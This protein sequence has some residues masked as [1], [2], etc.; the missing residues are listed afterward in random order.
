LRLTGTILPS[1]QRFAT[2]QCF[3]K[4]AS[5]GASRVAA[6]ATPALVLEDAFDKVI[7]WAGAAWVE[8]SSGVD[9]ARKPKSAAA[10]GGSA[11][12]GKRM[13]R[14][15]E[16]LGVVVDSDDDDGGGAE[17]GDGG[18]DGGDG[19]DEEGPVPRRT[20]AKRARPSA[21]ATVHDSD[22]E[23]AVASGG[24][25]VGDDSAPPARARR[26]AAAGSGTVAPGAQPGSSGSKAASPSRLQSMLAARPGGLLGALT[27]SAGVTGLRHW[28]SNPMAVLASFR[29]SVWTS[30]ARER[31]VHELDGGGGGGGATVNASVEVSQSDGED[32]I[33]LATAASPARPA[34]PPSA[35]RQPA[36]AATSLA[37]L[38]AAPAHSHAPVPVSTVAAQQGAPPPPPPPPPTAVEELPDWIMDA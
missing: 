19:A 28:S 16:A 7:L 13:R 8:G 29:S 31:A 22:D 26:S 18:G 5:A 27:A 3:P 37:A 2:L 10:G 9:P 4:I 24:G 17:G 33:D 38:M 35:T 14:E 15:L 21:A 23:E 25:G 6:T 1:R 34:L 11:V 20:R 30:P 12:G 36:A 32:V